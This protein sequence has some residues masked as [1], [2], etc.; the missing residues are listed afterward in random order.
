MSQANIEK[1][2]A[3]SNKWILSK[4][5]KLSKHQLIKSGDVIT[6]VDGNAV[7]AD[8]ALKVNYQGKDSTVVLSTSI[9]ANKLHVNLF[10]QEDGAD[11]DIPHKAQMM[12]AIT[13]QNTQHGLML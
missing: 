6:G 3:K 4:L 8:Q 12:N 5:I 2:L 9:D 1:S 13:S 10:Y 7:Y 11:I